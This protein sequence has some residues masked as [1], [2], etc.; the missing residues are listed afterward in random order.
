MVKT[1]GIKSEMLML[2]I[3]LILLLFPPYDILTERSEDDSIKQRVREVLGA[4]FVVTF[5]SRSRSLPL[6]LS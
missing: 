3:V 4:E 1:E 2:S 6:K 5:S